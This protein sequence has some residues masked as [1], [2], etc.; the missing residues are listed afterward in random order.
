M[1]H[2]SLH[3]YKTPW[4]W[5]MKFKN[6]VNHGVFMSS[7]IHGEGVC[8]EAKLLG[9]GHF[10]WVYGPYGFKRI[11]GYL[12]ITPPQSGPM[13]LDDILGHTMGEGS[14]MVFRHCSLCGTQEKRG[15]KPINDSGLGVYTP[16]SFGLYVYSLFI[17]H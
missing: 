7:W 13:G 9:I 3:T 8:K 6:M 2:T 5:T 1:H 10:F 14:W 16:L 17:F 12:M 15:N 11:D 4:I